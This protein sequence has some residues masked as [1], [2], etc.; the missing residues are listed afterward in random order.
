ME[1]LLQTAM[2]T[3]IQPII[4]LILAG[5]MLFG[6]KTIQILEMLK[7]LQSKKNQMNI[8]RNKGKEIKN[9]TEYLNNNSDLEKECIRAETIAKMSDF[10]ARLSQNKTIMIIEKK[11]QKEEELEILKLDKLIEEEKCQLYSE[12][13]VDEVERYN[14]VKFRQIN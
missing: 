6:A 9:K 14:V 11:N 8:E 4:V 10:D 7:E 1:L 13:N 5:I 2:I 12:S 3:S